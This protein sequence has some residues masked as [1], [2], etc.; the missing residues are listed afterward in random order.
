VGDGNEAARTD[1]SAGV[2][3]ILPVL[4]EADNIEPLLDGIHQALEH[5]PH[6][7]CLIDDGSVD[8]T[9]DIIRKR[10][11][12]PDHH[13]HLIQRVKTHRGSQR[14]SALLAGLQWGL[15]HTD[16]AV[17]VEMDGDGSHRPQE[18][19]LGVK[20]VDDGTADVAIASKFLQGSQV[21]NRTLARR[22]VSWACSIAVRVFIDSRVIDYS[23]GYRFYSR[24]SAEI[25]DR[26]Q[27]RY[28]SPIYLSELLALW[29]YSGMS[30][31]E[32]PT[33][34]I[35]RYE[36]ISKLRFTDLA[37]AL[38]AIFEISWRYHVTGFVMHPLAAPERSPAR[39]ALPRGE[40]IS[41]G[42]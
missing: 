31:R 40:V 24:K 25:A 16:H 28:G 41:S 35:G 8:G 12:Q 38:L 39:G 21:L 15:E 6:T 10:M 14:G 18:L 30:I 29:M 4:N 5:Q 36:G 33:Q 26:Y 2:L 22:F 3:I 13:L 19:P 7:V 34:Y 17:F 9:V 11:E 37:K 20:L 42:E 23:N 32:F 27:F 1:S